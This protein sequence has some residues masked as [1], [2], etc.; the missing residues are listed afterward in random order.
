ME[1]SLEVITYWKGNGMDF[2]F[3]AFFYI[4]DY[5]TLNFKVIDL[6][7]IIWEPKSALRVFRIEIK[8]RVLFRKKIFLTEL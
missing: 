3:S 7:L 2:D 5:L 8:L 4:Y 6:R 1:I